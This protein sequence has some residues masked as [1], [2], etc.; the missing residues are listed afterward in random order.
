MNF[1]LVFRLI[2]DLFIYLLPRFKQQFMLLVIVFEKI[3]PLRTQAA[4]LLAEFNSGRFSPFRLI[5][6]SSIV[7]QSYIKRSFIVGE[8]E[9]LK[10]G[11]L[12][13]CANA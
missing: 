2:T 4:S 1:A 9:L 11:I 3:L 10:V 5:F 13:F 7:S 8:L 12:H 6:A